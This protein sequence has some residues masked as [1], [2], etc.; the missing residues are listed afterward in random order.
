MS[1]IASQKSI[2]AGALRLILSGRAGAMM[3]AGLLTA[4]LITFKPFQPD[5]G[6][7]P[8]GGDIVN[9]LGFGTL[10]LLAVSSLLMLA[11]PRRVAALLSPWW[12]LLFGF[13]TLSVLNAPDSEAAMRAASF[14]AVAV[15]SIAAVIALP[16]S[17]EG[18][19]LVFGL[20]GFAVVGL[21]YLGLLIFPETAIHGDSLYEP[22]HAGF[23]RGSFSHKNIAGPVMAC[24]GFAGLYL[25]R[26]GRRFAG[27]TLFLAAMIFMANTGS[28]TTLGLVPMAIG[29]VMLPRF[30][31][32]RFLTPFLFVAALAGAA[33]AT[34]G[35]VFIEPFK[36][37]AN[38]L[39]PELTYTGRTAL[40]AFLGEMIVA[41]PWTGYGFESFWQTPVVTG[42][43]QPFDRDWNITGIVHGH[44]GYLDLAVTMGLPALGVGMVAFILAPLRDYMRVPPLKENVYL[45]DFFLMVLLFTTLNAFLES[46]FFRR[47][48]PVWLFLT[49]AALGLRLAAR[50]PLSASRSA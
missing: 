46:F 17:G 35:I 22:Q 49:M 18:Y 7:I 31:G 13:V 41:R 8:E 12:L 10:G 23:W 42:T 16:R 40:W 30:L 33:C 4:L 1:S 37:L 29:L 2:E 25:F 6:E 39:V 27:T 50:F 19:S 24:L 34:L 38:D 20:A 43:D 36:V 15:V 21:C 44:N 11:D 32:F 9:Q 26:R 28:K 5:G 47:A 14:S 3:A 48:D 45:A